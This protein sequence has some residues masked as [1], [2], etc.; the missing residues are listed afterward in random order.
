MR[1][2]LRAQNQPPQVKSA[3]LYQYSQEFFAVRNEHAKDICHDFEPQ[4]IDTDYVYWL[5]FHSLSD[6][7][8][9]EQLCQKLEIDKLSI[10][11]IFLP[12]RRSKVEEY[13]GYL[14]F[15]IHALNNQSG[16]ASDIEKITFVLGEHYLLSFQNDQGQHFGEVRQRI[17]KSKGKIRSQKSDFLLYRL[18]DALIDELFVKTEAVSDQIDILDEAIHKQMRGE[19]LRD[20]ETQKRELIELR[21][22]VQPIK[23]LLSGLESMDHPYIH[24]SNKH[25]FK[26]LRN[27]CIS[28][29]EDI[30]AHKQILDSLSNLYYA[31]QGQRMNE[32]MRILTVVSSI[33][34]PLTFIVGVY[35]MN[36]KY[37]PELDY[38]HGYYTVIGALFAIGLGLFLFFLKRG[39]LRKD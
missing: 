22:L 5:N 19:L 39:W 29:L 28:L 25:Y 37:M 1:S 7:T 10:E 12:L 14:F 31:A 8:S 36:F 33:F 20:I 27:S 18:L 38:P 24:K 13:S 2:R 30:D 3:Q 32:I 21:K 9:I 16:L 4:A 11:S 17:E 23:D 34:I 26:N 35:G 6:K 15:Q